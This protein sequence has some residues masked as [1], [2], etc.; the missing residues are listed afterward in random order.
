MFTVEHILPKTESLTAGWITMLANADAE[1]A[2]A[3]RK[4]WAH[5]LGNLTLSGYNANLG[6]MDYRRVRTRCLLVPVIAG[7]QFTIQVSPFR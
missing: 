1:G 6:R 3:I 4:Q 5:R 7:S 2:S